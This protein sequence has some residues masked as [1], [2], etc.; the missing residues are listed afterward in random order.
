MSIDHQ[1]MA[2]QWMASMRDI[3]LALVGEPIEAGAT[4]DAVAD[5]RALLRHVLRHRIVTVLSDLT[6]AERDLWAEAFYAWL[7]QDYRANRASAD[8]RPR[9]A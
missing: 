9:S 2:E 5:G 7:E 3:Y 8:P 6:E 4:P 1:A